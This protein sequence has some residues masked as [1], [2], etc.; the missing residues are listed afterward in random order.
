MTLVIIESCFFFENWMY[1]L[2]LPLI[3]WWILR[4]WT[5]PE[6]KCYWKAVSPDMKVGVVFGLIA[7]QRYGTDMPLWKGLQGRGDPYRTLLREATTALLN[8]Y[9]SVQFPF[10]PLGVIQDMN[11]AL[12]GSTRHVLHTALHFM[13]ANAGYG[14]VSCKF[15]PCKQWSRWFILLFWVYEAIFSMLYV[16]YL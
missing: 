15:T 11:W 12:M 16:I 6:Y 10:H 1:G 9:N 14:K 8:S 13:R 2:F 3:F 4:N 5:M 7:A